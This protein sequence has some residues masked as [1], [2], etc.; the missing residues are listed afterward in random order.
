MLLVYTRAKRGEIVGLWQEGTWIHFFVDEMDHELRM[1]DMVFLR[2]AKRYGMTAEAL[3]GL[4]E[5]NRLCEGE[6]P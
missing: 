5:T 1:W 3:R 4:I 2:R 6:K